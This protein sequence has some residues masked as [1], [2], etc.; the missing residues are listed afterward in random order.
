MAEKRTSEDP[1]RPIGQEPLVANGLRTGLPGRYRARLLHRNS[2]VG[3]DPDQH[4]HAE[5][6]DLAGEVAAPQCAYEAR[7]T[8]IACS[9]MSLSRRT[10]AAERGAA[11]TYR[12]CF[13][14]VDDPGLSAVRDRGGSGR[15]RWSCRWWCAGCPSPG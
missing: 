9:T 13:P 14:V 15:T 11:Q 5:R 4:V 10:T 7:G 12:M 6:V 3:G 1:N 2:G 8:G